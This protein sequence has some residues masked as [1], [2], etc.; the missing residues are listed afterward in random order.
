MTCGVDGCETPAKHKGLCGKHYKRQWRHGE[1]TKILIGEAGTYDKILRQRIRRYGREHNV[2][3]AH[4][5]GGMTTQGYWMLTT[6]PR[7]KQ[8]EHILIAEK[9]FGGPLPKGAIVHHINESRCDNRPENLLICPS[10][11][12]HL[13]IH[14][15]MRK[16]EWHEQREAIFAGAR[17]LME[18]M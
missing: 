8:L 9:M 18:I 2:R 10:Q 5:T 4:G 15:M 11:G 7:T 13:W 6:G 1:P 16:Q 17:A 14:R 12:Y 3:N